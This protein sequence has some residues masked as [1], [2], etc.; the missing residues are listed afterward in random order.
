MKRFDYW[1]PIINVMLP[2]MLEDALNK[3]DADGW[4]LITIFP[5]AWEKSGNPLRAI[6]SFYSEVVVVFRRQATKA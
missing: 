6:D 2:S 3:A 4:D 1:T 5:R